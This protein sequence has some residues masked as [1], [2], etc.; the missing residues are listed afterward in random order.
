MPA[1]SSAA[2]APYRIVIEP[3]PLTEEGDVVVW[4]A[5]HPDLPGCMAQGATPEEAVA[6]LAGAR[7]LYI[8]ALRK[9]GLPVPMPNMLRTTLSDQG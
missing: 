3:E 6:E 8:S 1:Q 4:M 9:R 5:S 2:S 7:E